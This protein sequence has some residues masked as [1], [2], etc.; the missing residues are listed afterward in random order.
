MSEKLTKEGLDKMLEIE[1]QIIYYVCPFCGSEPELL[2]G[3]YTI[4]CSECGATAPALEW[5]N[6][7]TKAQTLLNNKQEAI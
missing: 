1:K 5:N 3:G 7:N 6:R 2:I 4:K